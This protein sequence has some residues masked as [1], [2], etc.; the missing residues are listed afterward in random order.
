[1]TSDELF[2]AIT[3]AQ[4][5]LATAD[6]ILHGPLVNFVLKIL[7]QYDNVKLQSLWLLLQELT[8]TDAKVFAAEFDEIKADVLNSQQIDLTAISNAGEWLKNHPLVL[9][10]VANHFTN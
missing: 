6:K 7:N 4:S 10:F 1:M 8:G 3:N 5:T 2:Q 9:R